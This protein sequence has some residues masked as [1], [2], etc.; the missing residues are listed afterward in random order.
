MKKILVMLALMMACAGLS[1]AADINALG[2]P[3]A[4]APASAITD[5]FSYALAASRPNTLMMFN[6]TGNVFWVRLKL[7]GTWQTFAS[8]IPG[9]IIIPF[10]TPER[11]TDGTEWL[12]I[13]EVYSAA[14]SVSVFPTFR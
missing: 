11:S 3:H 7:A 2:L 9:N 5:T 6:G 1:Q 12:Y 10:S 4:I 14:D 13:Y 8:P